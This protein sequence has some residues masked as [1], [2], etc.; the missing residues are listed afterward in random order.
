[1]TRIQSINDE[2]EA[3]RTKAEESDHLKT[4]FLANMSHEIRTP[5]N[6]IMGFSELLRNDYLERSDQERY[7]DIIQQSGERMLNIINDLIDISKIEARQMEIRLEK[8]EV[9]ILLESLF[10]FFKPETDKK[11]IE[12]IQDPFPSIKTSLITTDKTKLTQ[13]LTNL[14]KNSIK[15]TKIGQIN[16]GYSKKGGNLEFYVRDTGIGIKLEIQDKIFERFRQADLSATR[17]YE[18]AGLGLSISRS[19]VEMLGG[20]IW[21]ESTPNEGSTFYFTIPLSKE[22]SN[23]KVEAKDEFPEELNLQNC[24]ILLVE[25][26]KTSLLLLQ[27]VFSEP[28]TKTLH[29]RNGKEAIAMLEKYPEINLV[30]MDIKMPLMNGFDATRKIKQMRPDLPVIAQTAFASPLDKQKSLDAG[31]DDYISKPILKEK[32]L[33]IIRR[34]I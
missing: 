31:C 1:M 2:L 21:L 11:K 28:E 7:I 4:A 20:K 27:E 23:E 33:E 14:I 8:T 15:Y 3:A 26:D 5:M 16:Y 32:L 12:L 18:G 22:T 6:G 34:H 9:N 17:P 25:D 19:F 30:L 10:T 29:A 24:N 13:I